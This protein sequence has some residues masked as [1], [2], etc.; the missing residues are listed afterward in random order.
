MQQSMHIS[1][2]DTRAARG[3]LM[4]IDDVDDCSLIA[5]RR[6]HTNEMCTSVVNSTAIVIGNFEFDTISI[7]SLK[8]SIY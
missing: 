1:P 3:R 7:F 5:H 6:V 4:N 2:G 8:I